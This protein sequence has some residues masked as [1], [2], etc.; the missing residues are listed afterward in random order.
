M[1]L[2]ITFHFRKSVVFVMPDINTEREHVIPD[3]ILNHLT[4]AYDHAEND[5][6]LYHLREALQIS[7]SETE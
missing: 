5:E 7:K 2:F 3:S 6:T 4:A 1:V